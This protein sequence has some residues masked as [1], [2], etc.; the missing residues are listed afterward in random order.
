[1]YLYFFCLSG[2]KSQCLCHASGLRGPFP[3]PPSRR[4][5]SAHPL[6]GSR[7]PRRVVHRSALACRPVDRCRTCLQEPSGRWYPCH[8]RGGRNDNKNCEQG[9]GGPKGGTRASISRTQ[10]LRV[11]YCA[12]Q[13]VAVLFAVGVEGWCD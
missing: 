4:H 1:M 10:G 2:D 3:L 12:V 6:L 11:G 9:R 5:R 7:E 13:G 8:P